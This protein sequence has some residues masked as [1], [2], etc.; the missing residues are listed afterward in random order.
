MLILL[1]S[2]I[3]TIPYYIDRRHT[4][5][6]INIV[7]KPPSYYSN[8]AKECNSVTEKTVSQL[9]AE[10]DVEG[11]GWF[12]PYFDLVAYWAPVF[13]QD[14]D[15]SYYKGDYIT[16][17]D[18][19][20]DWVG[21]N[22][23]ENLDNYD[24]IWA[25]VYYAV[26]ETETHYF[27]FYMFYHPRDW[28]EWNVL[29]EHEN[30]MEGAMIVIT[31]DGT[32]Y[33]SFLLME[34]RYHLWFKKY[35]NDP[36]IGGADGGVI[37]ENGKPVLFSEAKGHGITAWDGTD[38]PGGDGVIYRYRGNISEYPESGSDPDV[39][40]ALIPIIRSLWPRR[41]DIGDGRT[42]DDPFV[43]SGVRFSFTKAIGGAFDGDTYGDDKA[44]PPWGMDDGDDNVNRGDW[45]F[46]PAYT[47][48]DHLSIPY[49]FSL[50]YVYNPY[51]DENGP[52][53]NCPSITIQSPN[54]D[55]YVLTSSVNISWTVYDESS[56]FKVE[57]VVDG[58]TVYEGKE[59]GA[60]YVIVNL[61]DGKHSVNITAIDIWGNYRW[62]YR[63]F[64]VD[65][66]PPR[67]SITNPQN[68]TYTNNT[69][70]QISWSGYDENGIS[71]Y[72]LYV[73]NTLQMSLSAS[74]TTATL[75][76]AEGRNIIKVV[77]TD[78]AGRT[79]SSK[80]IV[81]IDLT[82]PSITITSPQ[83]NYSSPYKSSITVEW[84]SSDNMELDHFEVKVDNESWI[85]VYL[86]TSIV[87]ENL[88]LYNH[89]V[90]VKAVDKAGNSKIAL[91]EFS[92]N[93]S[94]PKLTSTNNNASNE[95][96]IA[97]ISGDI[98]YLAWEIEGDYDHTE[99][100][101]DN[102][103]TINVGKKTYYFLDGLSEGIH[104]VTL[105]VVYPSGEFV[106]K[107]YKVM[108]DYT[109]PKI[110][111]DQQILANDNSITLT[112][113]ASDELSGVDHYEILVSGSWRY[114]G[115]QTNYTINLDSFTDGLHLV[116][117]RAFDRVGNY[118]QQAIILI[119]DKSAPTLQ[120][121]SP[122]NESYIAKY[123]IT[124]SI[125]ATDTINV[126]LMEIYLNDSLVFK[127]E[128]RTSYLVKGL[129]EGTN[130]I[131]IR[132]YDS[133]N[134]YAEKKLVVHV[135][136]QPPTISI[137]EPSD[138][139]T[140][141]AS[142]I[143]V[144]W[145][146]SNDAYKYY[147][148]LDNNNWIYVGTSSQ[149]EF[150]DVPPGDHTITVMAIDHAG[151]RAIDIIV[152]TVQ[153]TGGKLRIFT[154]DRNEQLESTDHVGGIDIHYILRSINT[155]LKPAKKSYKQISNK[156]ESMSLSD[157]FR[158]TIKFLNRELYKYG[159]CISFIRLDVRCFLMSEE[160]RTK[161]VAVA[162]QIEKPI[163][164][165]PE[166]ELEEETINLDN[167]LRSAD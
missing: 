81:N 105:R 6:T 136:T 96:D 157:G 139:A 63:E 150:L 135:D 101:V 163:K 127:G 3:Y 158:P 10:G 61:D 79:N 167:V 26:I 32:Q 46:D 91:V 12:D 82:A 148:R 159:K 48:T 125:S 9:Y 43:Y 121:L 67:I 60:N 50:N 94:E 77:A 109:P 45:F 102:S 49:S 114:I 97:I 116:V 19:D 31:K 38:F 112:W 80:I 70:I 24:L 111:I 151:N 142:N 160:A 1:S 90:R 113:N 145:T 78:N 131:R 44:N 110:E 117:I 98:I 65:T 104:N 25:Y 37:F 99:I 107:T 73:N 20:G 58:N 85:N 133:A 115:N 57:V 122:A 71:S 40:Y 95:S 41:Y 52:E 103:T 35:T 53:W 141:S 155:N 93:P 21:N 69:E 130:I 72:D 84:Q 106:E 16:R 68:N 66:K 34:T 4:N 128:F 154:W 36:N 162:I 152:V 153:Q 149:Y 156:A 15:D 8:P 100:I 129:S 42:Y 138:G 64:Y 144:K 23:W 22:N 118:A 59:S 146:S 17:F 161:N 83:N 119:V 55:E 132:V 30:D 11:S 123:E 143:T 92:L 14:T 28:H 120:I 108:T 33:G 140:I 124:V 165:K 47:V 147:V 126:V 75:N 137:L 13:R 134:N 56:L 7:V 74:Q 166:E 5:Q 27:I 88:T 89:T 18:F 39:A 29:D 87:L 62:V 76:L 2:I 51:L 54:S 86:N 164:L